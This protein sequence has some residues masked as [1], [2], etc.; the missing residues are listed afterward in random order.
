MMSMNSRVDLSKSDLAVLLIVAHD[1]TS[2]L[3]LTSL[4]GRAVQAEVDIAPRV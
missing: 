1:A 3:A 2:P 4:S